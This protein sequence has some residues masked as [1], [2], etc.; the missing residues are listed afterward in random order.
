MKFS[1]ELSELRETKFSEIQARD[2]QNLYNRG[3]M[4]GIAYAEDY[5]RLIEKTHD[6]AMELLKQNIKRVFLRS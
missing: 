3:V 6:G 1:D 2:R 4:D 5:V